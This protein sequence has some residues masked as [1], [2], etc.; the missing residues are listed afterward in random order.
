MSTSTNTT[1]EV[2]TIERHLEHIG[3]VAIMLRSIELLR[4][5]HPRACINVRCQYPAL[6]KHPAIDNIYHSDQDLPESDILVNMDL[7]KY[8]SGTVKHEL[9]CNQLSDALQAHDL[10]G[11]E[12]DGRPQ[13]LWIPTQLK[14]WADAF[15]R[16]AAGEKIPIGV[17]WRAAEKNRTWNGMA[18]LVKMLA[19]SG[20]AVFCFDGEKKLSIN[21]PNVS[22]VVG[23]PLDRLTSLVER[24]KLI[25]TMDSAGLHI[26]GGVGTPFLAIFGTTDPLLLASMYVNAHWIKVPCSKQ[27]CWPK[28]CSWRP[29]LRR[30]KVT[31]VYDRVESILLPDRPPRKKRRKSNGIG[32]LRLDGLGGT[33]TLSDQAYKIKEKW[34]EKVTVIIRHHAELFEGNPY[35]DDIIQV[36]Y[37]KWEDTLA[38]YKDRFMALADIKFAVA[39]WYG[40]RF[41][42][43]APWQYYYDQFPL[44]QGQLSSLRMHHIQL[45]DKMLGLPYD[46][47]N[48]GLF[49][50]LDEGD[51]INALLP[52]NDYIVFA[53]GVDT[54]HKGL[55]Q[56][57]CWPHWN[58]LV[59]SASE[60]GYPKFL[61]VGTGFDPFTPGAIDLRGKTDLKQLAIVLKNAH[62]IIV[63]EG[64]IMHMAYAL[65]CKNVMVIRGSTASRL[66]Q[67]PGHVCVDSYN[68]KCCLFRTDDW[69]EHCPREM[70]EPICMKSISPERVLNAYEN[71]VAD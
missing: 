68:C 51:P 44:H 39:K 40:K 18:K 48:T 15:V 22:Q 7:V 10:E 45:T 9:F 43:F 11:I 29:C 41:Q 12:W 63:T 69:F 65:G 23:Y 62:S 46:T 30:I 24:M 36:G 54:I 67:Y 53:N 55:V 66:L 31:D 8:D 57:K 6:L 61:Q 60:D 28:P 38:E 49:F 35:I 13:T 14:R 1:S 21:S 50:D 2:I 52:S 20:C 70:V 59:E 42:W 5:A 58:R 33:L 64:G 19:N 26:A 71:M 17:F 37:V 25:I 27:P 56:T 16:N 47:I 3:D 34:D 32:L 4:L